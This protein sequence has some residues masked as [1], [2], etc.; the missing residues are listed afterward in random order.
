MITFTRYKKQKS[1]ILYMLASYE[2]LIFYEV[3][4]F[5]TYHKDLLKFS[6]LIKYEYNYQKTNN[7]NHYE[8]FIAKLI[9]E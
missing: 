8:C 1:E 3:T 4:R 9:I 6:L 7:C 2:I 5:F